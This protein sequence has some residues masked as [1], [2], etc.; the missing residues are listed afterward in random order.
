MGVPPTAGLTRRCPSTA[1]NTGSVT[2]VSG[3]RRDTSV[4]DSAFFSA[5]EPLVKDSP[6]LGV[7][8]IERDLFSTD[9][10]GQVHNHQLVCI[11][12][13]PAIQVW[14][15]AVEDCPIAVF[16]MNTA[17]ISTETFLAGAGG[18]N[19]FRR[20]ISPVSTLNHTTFKV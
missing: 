20:R 19:R 16:L 17:A 6:Y 5:L 14:I 7:M 18:V 15:A 9:P 2:P 10:F 11:T 3:P 8:E 13:V 12:L 1:D 4:S